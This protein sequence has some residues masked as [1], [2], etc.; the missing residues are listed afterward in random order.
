MRWNPRW[1]GSIHLP[2]ARDRTSC[3]SELPAGA[4]GSARRPAA[5]LVRRAGLLGLIW[6]ACGFA[7]AEPY[8][9]NIPDWAPPPAV[10]G[11]N[12]MNA[13]KVELGRRLFYDRRLSING[14]ISCASCHQ[15][16]R[17]FT[18]GNRVS[19][20]VTGQPGIRNAMSLTNV[21]FLSTLTWA[22]PSL[23]RL[24]LQAI[25]PL[26]NQHP[27]EMG[28]YGKEP[29]LIG[30]VASDTDYPRLF[31]AAFPE[32]KGRID[33]SSIVRALAAFGR[34]LL[35]FNS[36][37]DR[38]KFGGD[39]SALSDSAK[40][41]EALFYSD[42]LNCGRCHSGFNFTDNTYR[43]GPRPNAVFHNT[44]LY[45]V[46][47]NGSYPKEDAGLRL[48]TRAPGDEGRFRTPTLRNI[49][50]TAPYMHDGSIAT[51]PEVIRD[52]YAKGGMAAHSGQGASPLRNPLV[53]G[54]SI[55][56]AELDELIAFL[57]SLTDH[58][59]VTSEKLSDPFAAPR[60]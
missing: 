1:H 53:A 22:N 54:F 31:R 25:R 36:A 2:A 21:A 28:M 50:L 17:A 27:V 46:D 20:G 8:R 49:A 26:L 39:A 24:E 11:D 43:G 10:P 52:H 7:R 55:S 4:A 16:D 14:T 51:L 15:Q 5:E 44:G 58:E 32:T 19:V 30:K 35:S 34:T 23:T 12:P 33:L 3:K 60:R 40:R 38:Y 41:G 48:R 57:D 59:F 13:S 6:L 47:G 18:D 42:R 45:N 37:Y 9:W 29:E 56:E